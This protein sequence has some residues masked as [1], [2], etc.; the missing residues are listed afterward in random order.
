MV[1]NKRCI[2]AILRESLAMRKILAQS[3]RYAARIVSVGLK[4]FKFAMITSSAP[5]IPVAQSSR[6]NACTNRSREPA[7]YPCKRLQEANQPVLLKARRYPIIHALNV[8]LSSAAT[9]LLLKTEDRATM[10]IPA[11]TAIIAI[12]ERAQEPIIVPT[13]AIRLLARARFAT[14]KAV[15]YKIL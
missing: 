2:L 4:I 3:I 10:A 13:V 6:E 11:P 14:E 1:H 8:T 5:T 15:V 12:A 7:F 9:C